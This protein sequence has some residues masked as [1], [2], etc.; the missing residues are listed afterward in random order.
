M[1]FSL[2]GMGPPNLVQRCDDLGTPGT[3]MGIL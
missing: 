1:L 3:G 2:Q